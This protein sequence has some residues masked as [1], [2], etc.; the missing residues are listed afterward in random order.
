[1]RADGAEATFRP[2]DTAGMEVLTRE[3][4][5]YEHMLDGLKL[6]L[7]LNLMRE[8]MRDRAPFWRTR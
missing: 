1:V 4:D 8:V 3:L 2:F 7:N 5:A 6:D